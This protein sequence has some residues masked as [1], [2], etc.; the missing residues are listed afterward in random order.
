[1][2]GAVYFAARRR[3]YLK[4]A[5]QSAKSLK[6]HMPIGIRVVES[7]DEYNLRQAA[8]IAIEI[9]N[10]REIAYSRVQI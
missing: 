2:R 7:L 4:W 1:M 6:N 8:D 5:I 10:I 9:R 3:K